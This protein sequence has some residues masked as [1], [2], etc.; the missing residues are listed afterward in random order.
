MGEEEGVCTG[1][2]GLAVPRCIPAGPTGKVGIGG[3]GSGAYLSLV[4]VGL[5]GVDPVVVDDVLEGSGHEPAAAAPVPLR[6]GAVHEVLGAQRHQGPRLQLHL[7]LERSH[8]AEGPARAAGTLREPRRCSDPA[9]G[10]G[11]EGAQGEL[12][13]WFFT[14]VTHPF[15]RQSTV[16]GRRLRGCGR[17][18]EMRWDLGAML[19]PVNKAA[20]SLLV[21]GGGRKQWLTMGSPLHTG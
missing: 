16:S 15:S 13:T 2:S 8:G 11:H 10:P 9:R 4:G 1:G 21:W 19:S 20:T 6:H 12:Q 7:R 18:A 3:P 17:D 5:L 14:S